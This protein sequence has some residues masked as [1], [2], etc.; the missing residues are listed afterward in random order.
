M[1]SSVEEA[2]EYCAIEFAMEVLGGRWK[3]AILKQLVS[4][5]HRF[6]ELRRALPGITQRMLT[7]QLRELE[8]D[9]LVTRTVH[10]EVPPRVEYALTDVGRSLDAITAQL[11][12]W[13]RWYQE[14]VRRT[15]AAGAGAEPAGTGSHS[16]VRISS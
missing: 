12:T 9:G 8:A 4:G 15:P 14:T 7:R 2:P 16:V 6:G 11:D 3:L 1:R 10:R 5:T 13:G